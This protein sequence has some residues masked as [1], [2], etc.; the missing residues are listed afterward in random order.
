[1]MPFLH[2]GKYGKLQSIKR[3]N[4]INSKYTA[5]FKQKNDS[6]VLAKPDQICTKFTK[7]LMKFKI[8]YFKTRL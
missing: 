4:I 7:T 8:T 6:I 1:M 3:M 2:K 5:F